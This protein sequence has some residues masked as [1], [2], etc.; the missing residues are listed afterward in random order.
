MA[1]V[2]EAS[3]E[4]PGN[5]TPTRGFKD[6]SYNDF[7]QAAEKLEPFIERAAQEGGDAEVG[8]IIY[9]ATSETKNVN[10]GIVIMFVPLAAVK[11]GS[12]KKLIGSLTPRDTQ[13][14]VE[15]MRKGKLGGM[16]LRDKN[17]S[18]YDIFSKGIFKTIEEGGI[19]PLK[20]MKMAQPHDTLAREWVGDYPISRAIA[21]RID[22]DPK[23]IVDEYLRTLSEHPDTLIAR[24]AGLEEAKNVSRMAREVLSGGLNANEFDS[25][26]RSRGNSLNPGT[27]ADLVAT[28]L[29]LKLIG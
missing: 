8:K 21:K 3:A 11:G 7:I 19:T 17:L 1:C 16:E 5:V 23:S 24:K 9:E 13:W 10:F 20:L 12:T 25:Y 15:A 29:F 22:A 4:K 6:L 26:L 27:T 2:M 14:I 18:K 28:G